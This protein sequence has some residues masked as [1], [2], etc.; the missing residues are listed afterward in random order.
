MTLWNIFLSS[1]CWLKY[2]PEYA[3]LTPLEEFGVWS[4]KK[5]M[6]GLMKA[7]WQWV[8]YG[9]AMVLYW[10]VPAGFVQL[11][12]FNISTWRNLMPCWKVLI[13]CYSGEPRWYNCTL[14]RYACTI[15]WQTSWLK[16]LDEDKSCKWNTGV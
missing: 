6:H 10:K 1:N 16:S 11:A 5:W 9:K 4:E 12:M 13:S 8:W 3:K 2:W 15:G 14:I 7:L